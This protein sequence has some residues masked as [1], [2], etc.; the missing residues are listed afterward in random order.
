MLAGMKVRI[1]LYEAHFVSASI[2]W[3]LIERTTF[4][5]LKEFLIWDIEP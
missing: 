1:Y 4:E 2:W 5:K 3:L